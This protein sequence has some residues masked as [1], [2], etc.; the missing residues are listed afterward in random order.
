MKTLFHDYERLVDS[1]DRKLRE[2]ALAIVEAGVRRV[3]PYDAVRELIQFDGKQIRMGELELLLDDIEHIYVV[4]AGKGSFPIAQA[5]DE[6]FGSRITKG[7]VVVKGGEK[8][9]LE[10]IEIFESSHPVPD[11]RSIQAADRLIEILNEAGEKDLVFAAVTGGSSALVNKPVGEINIEDLKEINTMLLN[12]GAEIGKINTVRKHICLLKGGH[13][14]KLGQPAMVVTLTFDTSPPDMPW[15]DLC[16]PDPTTFEEAVQIMKEYGLWDAAPEHVKEYLLYGLKNP[17]LETVKSLSGMKQAVF[18]VADPRLACTAAA[19]Q[20]EK[21]GYEPHILSTIMAGEAKD[22]GIVMA[23]IADEIIDYS[24]PFQAPCALISGGETTVTIQGEHGTGG[25]NQET[26]LGFASK[27][28][29]EKGYA[30]VSMDTD[31]TDGPCEKAGGI[32]DGRTLEKAREKEIR[33]ETSLHRHNSSEML[34]VLGDD[35]VTGHT[36]TNVMNLRVLLIG[37]EV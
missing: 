17:E 30:F 37:K 21:L 27:I 18:S 3:I 24:R 36:G 9:R 5:L 29:H 16:L 28:R 11:E 20:A 33:F 7:F 8:R 35:L 12:C 19:E 4:G 1:K 2:D 10:H 32:V 13:L 14:V 26:V 25:P 6:I 34:E 22:V 15:P 31:G 23:G